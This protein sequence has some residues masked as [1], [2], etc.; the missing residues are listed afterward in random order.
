[1]RGDGILTPEL[2][3]NVGW[4]H[5]SRVSNAVLGDLD[6]ISEAMD[7]GI[8][9][10]QVTE[11]VSMVEWESHNDQILLIVHLGGIKPNLD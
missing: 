1:M 10:G 7:E 8:T 9:D 3:G 5:L 4:T 6:A 11:F 2:H